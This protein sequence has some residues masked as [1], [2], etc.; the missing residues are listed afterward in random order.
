M[1]DSNENG[2]PSQEL[3]QVVLCDTV[4]DESTILGTRI[5]M[6]PSSKERVMQVASSY[7]RGFAT[8]LWVDTEGNMCFGDSFLPK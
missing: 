7:G 5:E 8:T 4:E 1:Q 6:I 2:T 3:P